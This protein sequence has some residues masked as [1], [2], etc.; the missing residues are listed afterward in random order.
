[1]IICYS[2]NCYHFFMQKIFSIFLTFFL[3]FWFTH[4]NHE[5]ENGS[6]KL[7]K[8]FNL[9]S[10]NLGKELTRKEF[11]E[12]LHAW[13]QSY[14]KSRGLYVDYENYTQLD[15]KKYF[16]DVDLDS[17]F[18]EKLEYF[19]HLW[20]FSKNEYFDPKW[21]VD[22][23]TFFIVMSRLKIMW[24]LQHCKNLRICEKEADDKTYFTKWVYYKYVSK[25]FYKELR[26]YYSTPKQYIDAGYKPY[27]KPNYYFP[28]ASQTLNGCYA[29]T[30]RNILK[31]KHNIWVYIPR[32]E[33]YI[34]KEGKDLWKYPIMKEYD[35]ITHVERKHFY[36]LDTLIS[37]LQAGEPV[38]VSY[39]LDYY[40]YKEKKMKQ[41]AHI[42][43]AYSFDENW[44]WVAETVAGQRK[45]VKWDKI[46]NSYGGVQLN[47]IFKFYY[48]PKQNW[49]KEQIKLENEHNFLAWE[50]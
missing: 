26:K 22:Q 37:S 13:Y 50:K 28:N 6:K 27:L 5:L 47:R 36:H 23:K 4:A 42:T 45:L 3:F 33:K 14:R 20:A 19:A 7:V 49:T 46:I 31:Y 29:F 34:G 44:V 10:Y 40:S 43:A 24:N 25:I 30:V 48:N 38:W 8:E 15:N 9:N 39:M 18:W 16:K 32:A 17:E 12:T 2:V 1:M 35:A 41:V 21:T 11:V